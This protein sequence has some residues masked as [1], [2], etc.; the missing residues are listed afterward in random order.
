MTTD[1]QDEFWTPNGFGGDVFVIASGP[2]L[3]DVD[4]ERL[5]GRNTIVVN[6]SYAAAP[7]ADV[8]FFMDNGWFYQ[9]R[10]IVEAW[11]SLVVTCSRAAKREMPNKVNRVQHETRPDFPPAGSPCIRGGRSSG[12]MAVSLAIAMGAARV[13]LVGFDMRI[14]DG[15]SHHHDDYAD[16]NL[17]HQ[18]VVLNEFV[19]GFEGWNAA[20]LARG[21]TILN[22]TPGS[23]VTEFPFVDL[24]DLI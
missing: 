22:A 11:P 7:W 1:R 12:H 3:A 20:A 15:R 5:R 13:V 6:S 23:A 18:A 2:S 19:E 16:R 24:D 8:L 17:D 10:E 9:H 14:V 4:L 21:C